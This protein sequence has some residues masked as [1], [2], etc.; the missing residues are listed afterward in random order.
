MATNTSTYGNTYNIQSKIRNRKSIFDTGYIS[1]SKDAWYG[2]DH[3]REKAYLQWNT[4]TFSNLGLS[5]YLLT[6][7]ASD[8]IW[9]LLITDVTE[10]HT[11]LY[12]QHDTLAG[13]V[14]YFATG[15][16]S[17]KMTITAKLAISGSADYRTAFLYQYIK[18]M[19]AKQLSYNDC[20]L[21]FILKDTTS[22]IY[23]LNLQLSE[24]SAE[25]DMANLVISCLSYLYKNTYST[26]NLYTTVYTKSMPVVRVATTPK[27]TEMNELANVPLS[28]AGVDAPAPVEKANK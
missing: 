19:R 1:T 26:E 14:C 21:G 24:S 3:F 6:A 13:T 25:P 17:I 9:E 22:K 18:N 12:S 5:N 15:P 2:D 16:A 8:A 27:K 11:E 10:N 20:L 4:S 28:D 23:I 7:I